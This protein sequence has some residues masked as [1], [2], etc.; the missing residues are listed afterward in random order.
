MTITTPQ[1]TFLHLRLTMPGLFLRIE[2]WAVFAAVLMLYAHQGFSW[3][4]FIFLFFAPDLSIATFSLNKQWGSI[5]YNLIHT[6]ALPLLLA[7]TSLLF[8]R[9][10][11][12]QLTLIWLAHIA[13]DRAIGYGFKYMGQ[14]KKTHL[15]QV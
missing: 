9:S 15:S 1:P 11:G 6:Y 7:A 4:A 5:I 3:L 10:L 14:F 12:L 2:G 8:D 13:L